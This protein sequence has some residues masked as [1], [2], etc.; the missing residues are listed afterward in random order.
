MSKIS[1]ALHWFGNTWL[2]CGFIPIG[3]LFSRHPLILV[4]MGVFFAIHWGYLLLHFEA[5]QVLWSD[6]PWP[7]VITG[8][9]IGTLCGWVMTACWWLDNKRAGTRASEA[10]EWVAEPNRAD[11]ATVAS[12]NQAAQQTPHV[13]AESHIAGWVLLCV[14][15]ILPAFV[16]SELFHPDIVAN[17]DG[18]K[19]PPIP[20]P[21]EV[22]I[23]GIHLARFYVPLGVFV[24]L[25]VGLVFYFLPL[26]KTFSQRRLQW[27]G[28]GPPYAVAGAYVGFSIMHWL[29]P[30]AF[31][32]FNFSWL[33][34]AHTGLL[35]LGV[36]VLAATWL[37]RFGYSRVGR[38][39]FYPLVMGVPLLYVLRGGCLEPVHEVPGLEMYYADK[40]RDKDK[41]NGP[42]HRPQLE[43]YMV[44]RRYKNQPGWEK[45]PEE[46]VGWDLV[47]DVEPL[48]KWGKAE[49]NQSPDAPVV[50]L[51]VSGGASTSAVFVA[52]SLFRLETHHPGFLERIRIISGA[53]GGM[54]GA[55]HFVTQFRPGSPYRWDARVEGYRQFLERFGTKKYA[56]D[57]KELPTAQAFETSYQHYKD[58]LDDPTPLNAL[59]G[60][61]GMPFSLTYRKHLEA[62]YLAAMDA[63][64]QRY[65]EGMEKDFLA[66]V[67][68]KWVHKDIN[69]L[70]RFF[71]QSTPND[72]GT[73]LELAWKEYLRGRPKPGPRPADQ[74]VWWDWDEPSLDVPFSALRN[75]EKEAL[76]P[77]LV[78]TPMLVEDGRQLIISNLDLSYMVFHGT[79]PSTTPIAENVPRDPRILPKFDGTDPPDVIPALSALEFYRLFPEAT[80]TFK[81][82]TA[83]RL[84]AT[85]PVLSPAA[86]LPTNPPRRVVD[87]GYYDNYGLVVASRWIEGKRDWFTTF[88][89]TVWVIELWTYG[90][91]TPSKSLVS[92]EEKDLLRDQPQ[93]YRVIPD[94]G[95]RSSTLPIGAIYNAWDASMANRGE[96]RLNGILHRMNLERWT[97]NEQLKKQ[98]KE[99]LPFPAAD[100]SRYDINDL[101]VAMNWVLSAKSLAALNR[102]SEQAMQIAEHTRTSSRA[103]GVVRVGEVV[104]QLGDP[105]ASSAQ[106]TGLQEKAALADK[107]YYLSRKKPALPPVAVIPNQP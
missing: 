36:G 13:D 81:L 45:K 24:A 5:F 7:C 14:L 86:E 72:R 66:P 47:R 9:L 82:S 55:A 60:V 16:R 30:N 19:P 22:T 67:F 68:E 64:E 84:N 94:P 34:A 63:L 102:A 78:F 103:S 97:E 98:R 90:Y 52:R 75:E 4:P 28:W 62:D 15:A 57:V 3:H 48:G 6:R 77:S 69:P 87:A 56:R 91:T 25:G 85:F 70:V 23:W 76:I 73:A 58:F 8:V 106:Q 35:F 32:A 104:G 20:L 88:E 61:L 83:V 11:A 105:K 53:S 51:S 12:V 38:C 93:N 29:R 74:P 2:G 92:K 43:N 99:R 54:L 96:E 10:A 40:E 44:S 42:E 26:T 50:V 41:R 49:R 65:M 31:L 46:R 1:D 27:L 89:R 100:R 37:H 17:E 21:P 101:D 79:L 95:L 59:A 80:D 107:L 71:P 33:T 18:T 39:W